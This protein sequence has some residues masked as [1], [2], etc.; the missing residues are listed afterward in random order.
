M[1]CSSA[2]SGK[3][4]QGAAARWAYADVAGDELVAVEGLHEGFPA[5]EEDEE[6]TE[7]EAVDGAEDLPLGAVGVVFVIAAV[8]SVVA[9]AVV[10]C[11]S[12]EARAHMLDQTS[13]REI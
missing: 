4:R 1:I 12:L 9:Y 5:G 10:F 11:C 7:G 2:V 6:Y 13:F 8:S 3:K